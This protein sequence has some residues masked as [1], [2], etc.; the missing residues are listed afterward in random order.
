M[1]HINCYEKLKKKN[2]EYYQNDTMWH[3]KNEL[4]YPNEA[5]HNQKIKEHQRNY[6]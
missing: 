6:R 3:L 4:S 1:K 5:T 2:F